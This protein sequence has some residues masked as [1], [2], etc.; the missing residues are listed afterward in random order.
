MSFRKLPIT[1]VGGGIGGREVEPPVRKNF[2]LPPGMGDI[3]V[4]LG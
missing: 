2:G 3:K 1:R 4:R